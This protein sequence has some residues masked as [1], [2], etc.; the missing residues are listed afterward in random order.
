MTAYERPPIFTKHHD[1]TVTISH[2]P[3]TLQVD[4][5][6]L[7]MAGKGELFGL[8]IT[9]DRLVID[10]ANGRGE[11]LMGPVDEWSQVRQCQRIYLKETE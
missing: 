9:G 5:G 1:G 2:W 11:Y 3:E 6:F 4:L 7:V 8:L 10:V